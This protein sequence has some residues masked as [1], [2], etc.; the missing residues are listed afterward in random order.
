MPPSIRAK[1]LS[2]QTSPWRCLSTARFAREGEDQDSGKL[3]VNHSGR[4][5][6]VNSGVPH[7]IAFCVSSLMTSFTKRLGTSFTL[8][9]W[10]DRLGESK[11]AVDEDRCGGAKSAVCGSSRAGG[12]RKLE[13][14]PFNR[15]L[16]VQ[17]HDI[18]YKTSRDILYTLRAGST[19]SGGYELRSSRLSSASDRGCQRCTRIEDRL[20]RSSSR[21][22]VRQ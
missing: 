12:P 16:C 6:Q 22:R 19:G 14:A 8:P 20:C 5:A 15:V 7:S 17:S 11:D 1:S 21:I 10:L 2:R 3:T 9:R 18:L 4:V 13:G